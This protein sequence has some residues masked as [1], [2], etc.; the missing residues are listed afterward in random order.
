MQKSGYEGSQ[1]AA[2]MA[3]GDEVGT[4]GRGV[5]VATTI[6]ACVEVAAKISA[7]VGVSVG[8]ALA[9]T[10]G[11]GVAVSTTIAAVGRRV[12]SAVS[13]GCPAFLPV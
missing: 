8:V 7:T 4:I 2:G 13:T 1:F 9:V 10:L 6:G 12:G 5:L 11:L 3:A